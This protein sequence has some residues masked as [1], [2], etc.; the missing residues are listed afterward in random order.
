MQT[1]FD[2]DKFAAALKREL[3][4]G[5]RV[6]WQARALSRIKKSSLATFLFAIP[7]T[8]FALFWMS[9]ATYGVQSGAGSGSW[10]DYAFPAFGLPFVAIGIVMLCSPLLSRISA[11][12]TMFAITDQRV[13]RIYV[14]KTVMSESI[15]L[16]SVGSIEKTERPDGTGSLQVGLSSLAS[17]GKPIDLG[18]V[19]NIRDVDHKLRDAR[20]R[21]KRSRSAD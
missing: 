13:M 12:R 6:I 11:G 1:G 9:M 8:A 21:A 18:Q 7:W 2:Q 19:E 16:E 5:E 15:P 10:L 3:Q 4:R 17:A 20:E 14:G